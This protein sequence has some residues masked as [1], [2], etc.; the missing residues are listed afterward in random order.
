MRRIALEQAEHSARRAKDEKNADDSRQDIPAVWKQ[1][2][3]EGEVHEHNHNRRKPKPLEE[4]VDPL[5][6][7]GILAHR[8]GT[9]NRQLCGRDCLSTLRCFLNQ[10]FD[11]PRP[12]SNSR[13]LSW[14]S[15]GRIWTLLLGQVGT[16]RRAV[17]AFTEELRTA[18]DSRPYPGNGM[19]AVTRCTLL[20]R[21]GCAGSWSAN[22]AAGRESPRAAALPQR[23]SPPLGTTSL[24]RGTA[25]TTRWVR[26]CRCEELAR[27][28]Q[29]RVV[30]AKRSQI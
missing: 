7:W 16:A 18:G 25:A 30:F 12:V 26:R 21:C 28:F 14:H 2:H 20:C 19:V 4:D 27:F 8:I 15:A 3:A 13:P 9:V 10:P 29:K 24:S 22:A 11:C 1:V 6:N 23:G 17:R 5:H